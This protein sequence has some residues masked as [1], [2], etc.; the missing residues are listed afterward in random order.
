MAGVTSV[1]LDPEIEA[2]FRE[3]GSTYGNRSETMRKAI[4]KLAELKRREE[5][6]REVSAAANDPDDRA[7]MASVLAEMEDL[8]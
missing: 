3:L 7:E 4:L 8:G 2:A 6:R 1:R 5:L